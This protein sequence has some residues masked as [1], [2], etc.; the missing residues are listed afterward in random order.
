[1][2]KPQHDDVPAFPQSRAARRLLFPREPPLNISARSW[3]ETGDRVPISGFIVSGNAPKRVAESALITSYG[4]APTDNLESAIA[5]SLL[6][7][8]YSAIVGDKS[9]QTGVGLVEIYDLQ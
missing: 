3:L 7:D 5:T 2:Q 4:L 9:G 6:P 1:M 8:Q